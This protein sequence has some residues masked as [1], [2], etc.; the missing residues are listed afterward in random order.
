MWIKG[1]GS[2]SHLGGGGGLVTFKACSF[3]AK[4]ASPHVVGNHKL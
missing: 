2:F 1:L 4:K 3:M